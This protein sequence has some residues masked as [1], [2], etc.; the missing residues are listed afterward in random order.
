MSIIGSNVLA[1]ASGSGVDA[2]EIEQSLRFNSADSTYLYRTPASA[3]NKQVFTI[4]FWIKR[5][6]LGG[7]D[8]CTGDDQNGFLI[9]FQTGDALY[10]YDPNAASGGFQ[11]WSA[12]VFR[13]LSAWY[14]IVVA[15]DSTQATDS[16]RVKV[17]INGEQEDLSTWN[18]GSGASRYP[19]QNANLDWN[20][21]N[22]HEIGTSNN[23]G[24]LDGYLAEFHNVDGYQL[25]HEDFGELDDNGVWR[26]IEF[27]PT[28]VAQTPSYTSTYVSGMSNTDTPQYIFDGSLQTAG[29]RSVSGAGTFSYSGS[30]N[31]SGATTV[32]MRV[33]LGASSSQVGSNTNLFTV[34]GTDVTQKA[35]DANAFAA[36]GPQWIDITTEA[37]NAITA[38]AGKHISGVCNCQIY[39]IDIDGVLVRDA[40]SG[41]GHN[42]FYLKFD[43]S[44]TNGI[45]HDHS[46]DG[47]N[48]TASS[49]ITSAPG[50]GRYAP[51]CSTVSG[52]GSFVRAFDGSISTGVG[53]ENF[54]GEIWTWEPDTAYS[55]STSVEIY[56]GEAAHDEARINGGAWQDLNG[57]WKTLA[58]GS[59]SITK[60]EVRDDRGNAAASF[61]AFRV[62]GTFLVDNVYNVTYDVVPDTPTNNWSTV[63]PLHN[64]GTN[65]SQDGSLVIY[66]STTAHRVN[67]GTISLSSQGGKYYAECWV[68]TTTRLSNRA[69]GFGFQVGS[70][71]NGPTGS[72]NYIIYS[73]N[74]QGRISANGSTLA[75]NI[76]AA[77]ARDGDVY[78]LAF[79]AATGK[80]WVGMNNT[81][82]NSSGGSTGDPATG[83]NPT[84]TLSGDVYTFASAYNNTVYLNFGQYDFVYDAPTGFDSVNTANMTAP[85][86]KDGSDYFNTVL[87]T[88]NATARDITTGHN[89]NFTWIKHRSSA[90]NHNIYDI[91]RGTGN[92]V[93]SN[94]T[95]KEINYTDRLT[96]FNS[97]GF[98]LGTGYNN[99]NTTT[100]VGWSWAG[101]GSGS[102]NTDGSITSTVSASPSSGFSIVT[103]EGTNAA[104]TVGHGL[105]VA[106]SLVITRNRDSNSVN[107]RVQHASLGPTKYLSLNLTAAVG[108]ASSVWNDTAPT[109]TVFS[110]ANDGGSNGSS[111][112]MVAYCF[113]EV[114][115]YSRIS[116][117]TANANSDGPFIYCGFKPALIIF[118][119]TSTTEAWSIFDAARNDYNGPDAK[120]LLPSSNAAEATS[121][122]RDIDF[123][124]NGF[125]LRVASANNPNTN[126]GNVYIFAAFASSP[127]GGDGVS[128]V[129]AR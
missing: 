127:F 107:W 2:Y 116:S 58:T 59:G 118:K 23:Y 56:G 74:N 31:T 125:K 1:G 75:N 101:G 66:S 45:G 80:A 21:T 38:F 123:L 114:E 9:N 91:L 67:T 11:I 94:S 92:R 30:I 20:N 41:W 34:N 55:Y 15:I 47:N 63:N 126:S 119:N 122:G 129:T 110:V 105:G 98:S 87:W 70:D 8:I 12:R 124:S 7:K 84:F 35:K 82:L 32:R 5:S 39:A 37:G 90:E 29:N 49:F 25:D 109:S 57:G 106:P 65:G 95:D 86:I 16:N 111:Q 28:A 24:Y 10:L 61:N 88:G 52:G 14:H 50:N 104:A 112:D 121:S 108:T 68:H 97:D 60:I 100:Y 6:A 4:S 27:A 93:E 103:Y 72:N 96:A 42:G 53:S 22:S 43:P 78:Q 81:W 64:T 79:D 17:Y 99:T 62:D 115:G 76:S 40:V 89:S 51:D 26:P 77:M 73:N 44:A 83:A 46:G 13:D 113:A 48:F 117:Y 128:P 69:A 19:T 120:M 18:V 102:S 3:G 71:L 33:N 54:S 36:D 85:D